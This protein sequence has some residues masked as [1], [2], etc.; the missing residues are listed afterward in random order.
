MKESSLPIVTFLIDD[1]R[2][3]FPLASV[4]K[5][6]RAVAIRK[7]P[8]TSELIDGVFDF[9]GTIIPLVNLRK[10]FGMA[11]RSLAVNDRII[12][13][14]TPQGQLAVSVDQ[15]EQVQFVNTDDLVDIPLGRTN[16][17]VE[18]KTDTTLQEPLLLRDKNGIVVICHLPQLISKDLLIELEKIIQQMDAVSS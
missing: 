13:V 2:F 12:I 17:A 8:E 6:I 3:A 16:H 18:K 9:H 14:N 10:R 5:V 7:V 15:M 11:E 1:H 4:G